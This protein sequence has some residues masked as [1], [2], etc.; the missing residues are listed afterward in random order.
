MF[1]NSCTIRRNYIT[2]KALFFQLVRYTRVGTSGCKYNFDTLLSSFFPRLPLFLMKFYCSN[3]DK[4]HLNQGLIILPQI[5][6]LKFSLAF[7]Q[8]NA[9]KRISFAFYCQD[10]ACQSIWIACLLPLFFCVYLPNK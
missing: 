4:Y 2:K 6:L 5:H 10:N 7:H 1:G 8:G 9:N 3:S